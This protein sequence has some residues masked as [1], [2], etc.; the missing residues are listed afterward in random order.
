[1]KGKSHQDR[2]K[3]KTRDGGGNIV[4]ITKNKMLWTLFALSI[5]SLLFG[6]SLADEST[7]VDETII[8][9][10][11]Q[12]ATQLGLNPIP[13]Y[14]NEKG[15]IIIVQGTAFSIRNGRWAL[16]NGDMLINAGSRPVPANGIILNK[17]EYAVV[18]NYKIKKFP[19]TLIS[20][21]QKEKQKSNTKQDTNITETKDAE[22]YVKNAQKTGITI[23]GIIANLE[24]GK[25]FIGKDSYL[26]LLY[27]K[28]VGKVGSLARIKI[29][30]TIREEYIFLISDL[31]KIPI[32]HDGVFEFKLGSLRPGKYFI[33]VQG[34]KQ[35]PPINMRG[36]GFK[37]LQPYLANK[38]K[39]EWV[40]IEITDN[41]TLPLTFDLDKVYLSVE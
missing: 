18:E 30:Y 34:I 15:E 3:D 14:V 17:G 28:E 7:E 10:G 5:L 8:Q 23:K 16:D 6:L 4:M 39:G 21:L 13:V 35:P 20:N 24:D 33:I 37:Q 22:K 32:P 19:D 25:S 2:T 31:A 26:Q 12:K 1:M 40:E 9:A 38:P 27:R 36:P 11:R 41:I 29:D